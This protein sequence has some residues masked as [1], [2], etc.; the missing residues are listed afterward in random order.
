ML[1]SAFTRLLGSLA[2][3]SLAAPA[4]AITFSLDTT[5]EID[6]R[7]PLGAAETVTLTGTT[8]W[9]VPF[10]GP[11]EGDAN[12]SDGDGLDDLDTELLSM[13][14]TGVSSLLG[15]LELQ[16]LAGLTASGEVEE[17]VNNTSG[18]LDVPPYASGLANS[19]FDLV[20][21]IQAISPGDTYRTATPLRFGS[22]IVDLP[23]LN[24]IYETPATVPLF[25]EFG[26]S[27]GYLLGPGRFVFTNVVPE[28]TT[29]SLLLLGLVALAGRG[30]RRSTC[31][32]S[33]H[34]RT[35]KESGA[36]KPNE[37]KPDGY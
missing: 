4:S 6:L 24:G 10:E 16:L 32:F 15:P 11:T 21:D 27:T 2:L 22:T 25:D 13:I 37:I 14:L 18:K 9:D 29:G 19:S 3:V 28:P 33:I 35:A 26:A 12:D 1:R 30:R 17:K 31:L 8:V 5:M 23:G 20:F 34:P 7:N 36:E